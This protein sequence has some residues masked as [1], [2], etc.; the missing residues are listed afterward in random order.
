MKNT[1]IAIIVF[2]ALTSTAFAGRGAELYKTCVRC[3]GESGEG[4]LSEKAP[5]IAGQHDWYI[6]KAL[7]DFKSGARKNPTMLPFI[8]NLS[9]NDFAELSAYVSKLKVK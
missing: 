5:Q 8:K 9:Q 2:L 6:L 3:H 7:N 4:K 1:K